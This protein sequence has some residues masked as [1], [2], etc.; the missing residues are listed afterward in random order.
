[1]QVSRGFDRAGVRRGTP[2]PAG[3]TG[4]GPSPQGR[5]HQPARGAMPRLT[6]GCVVSRAPT[7]AQGRP[8]ERSPGPLP[9]GMI[10]LASLGGA[11][12]LYDFVVFGVFASVIAASFFLAT[13]PEL[14]QLLAF[15]GFAIGYFARPV[16]GVVLGHLGDRV[17]RRRV[18]VGSVLVVPFAT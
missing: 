1:D 7:A 11:L 5:K 8:V 14:G 15:A 12:E 4:R 3:E 18:F 9:R 16:G 13:D 17:G 2:A 6:K 10:L